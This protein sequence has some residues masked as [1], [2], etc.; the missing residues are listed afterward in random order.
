MESVYEPEILEEYSQPDHQT[1]CESRMPLRLVRNDCDT[2][3][4]HGT[5]VLFAGLDR[6]SLYVLAVADKILDA[7]ISQSRS[8]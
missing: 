1:Y 6:L 7:I 8:A 5:N 3:G 4:G 2:Q